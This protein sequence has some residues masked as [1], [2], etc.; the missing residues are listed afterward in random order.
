MRHL[1]HPWIG[2]LVEASAN[3]TRVVW[4]RA[5]MPWSWPYSSR[6]LISFVSSVARSIDGAPCVPLTVDGV[7]HVVWGMSIRQK[8]VS[9]PSKQ[10]SV[11]FSI[12]SPW[13]AISYLGQYSSDFARRVHCASEVR[14]QVSSKEGILSA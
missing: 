14:V 3:S 4:P 12:R 9:C 7:S 11:A 8:M 13:E 10:P 6:R 2:P 1:V 5:G